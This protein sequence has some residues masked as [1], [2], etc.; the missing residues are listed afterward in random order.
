[1]RRHAA[2]LQSPMGIER[3]LVDTQE[4]LFAVAAERGTEARARSQQ[5]ALPLAERGLQLAD[6]HLRHTR[7]DDDDQMVIGDVSR[8]HRHWPAVGQRSEREVAQPEVVH[9]GAL[10][11]VERPGDQ[12]IRL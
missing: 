2:P 11:R 8:F 7:Q 12:T 10:P 1:M 3:R 6:A 9:A 5:H 4:E